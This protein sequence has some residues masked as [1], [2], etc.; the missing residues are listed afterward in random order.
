MWVVGFG[1]IS[2]AI[3]YAR[4]PGISPVIRMRNTNP[5]RST[6]GSIS[7]YSPK[8]PIIPATTLFVDDRYSFFIVIPLYHLLRKE[9]AMC[10]SSPTMRSSALRTLALIQINSDRSLVN[11]NSDVSHVVLPIVAVTLIIPLPYLVRMGS[12]YSRGTCAKYQPIS[13][14]HFHI[15]AV[16]EKVD[17]IGC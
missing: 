15:F 2:N 13:P 12:K 5:R 8:P 14:G 1:T 9:T 16:K 3:K 7:Q 10:T 6:T 11:G 17:F 4:T